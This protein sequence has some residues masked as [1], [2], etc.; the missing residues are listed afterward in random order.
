MQKSMPQNFHPIAEIANAMIAS[1]I[2]LPFGC[3]SAIIT[4]IVS[5][6]SSTINVVVGFFC[7]KNQLYMQV[8]GGNTKRGYVYFADFDP[9]IGSE[10]GGIRPCVIIQNDLGNRY[11]G[12]VIV[13]TITTQAKKDM[14]THVTVS[15]EDKRLYPKSIILTEQIRT[16]DKDRLK[17]FVGKLS[18]DTMKKV[19]DALKVSL[20]LNQEK[21]GDENL[22]GLI[23][24]NNHTITE[25]SYNGQPVVTFKDIDIVHDRP[26]G[27]ARRNFNTNKKT[28]NRGGRL[29]RTKF[30]RSKK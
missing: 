11:S 21:K 17:D 24:I 7:C 25:K 1:K 2:S 20:D 5:E 8:G 9:V 13:A 3:K 28:L 16:I 10:Q 14:R 27:T 6:Q 19:N 22:V 29:L 18:E 26:D 23:E 30:V 12:T 4:L 15:D